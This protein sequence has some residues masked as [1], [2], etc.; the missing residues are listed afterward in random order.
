MSIDRHN[1]PYKVAGAGLLVVAAIA[2]SFIYLQFRGDLAPKAELTVVS[3]RAGL[4]VERGAKVTYHGVEI[5]R[6]GRI[7]L[8]DDGGTSAAGLTLDVDP[9]YLDVIPVNVHAEIRATTVFGNK[10]VSLAAPESPS[11]ERLSNHGVI[12]AAAVTTEFNTLFETVT[13]IARRSNRSSIN[14]PLP[15]RPRRTPG[16]VNR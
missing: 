15:Q 16:V 4:M 3:D 10:Y 14:R 11:R 2:A 13:E 8:V 6:V 12:A 7:G 1:P 5:G 9:R